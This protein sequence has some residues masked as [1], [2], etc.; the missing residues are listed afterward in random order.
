MLF[1]Y[2]RIS[3][4][5]TVPGLKRFSAKKG[6]LSPGLSHIT[7]ITVRT[8]CGLSRTSTTAAATS[9]T[10][11]TSAS[12]ST[13][14]TATTWPCIAI[15]VVSGGTTACA[16]ACSCSAWLLGWCGWRRPIG[17]V[18]VVHGL[19]ALALL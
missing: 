2:F 4:S 15:T 14:W 1:W 5:A 16:F 6:S 17:T 11:T 10:S 3:L 8:A 13:A 7:I 19:L 9:T 18:L 12:A